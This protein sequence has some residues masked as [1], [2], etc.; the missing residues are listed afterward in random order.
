MKGQSRDED[1]TIPEQGELGMLTL[2]GRGESACEVDSGTD[3]L[4]VAG[5]GQATSPP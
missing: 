5:I 1:E 4:L 3:V 2:E